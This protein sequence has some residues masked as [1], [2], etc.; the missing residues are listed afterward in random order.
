MA[1]GAHRQW[2]GSEPLTRVTASI[3]ASD[4]I[5]LER[6]REQAGMSVSAQVS[7]LL[8]EAIAATKTKEE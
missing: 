3:P 2:A 7:R 8:H 5:E 6:R 1:N 4:L